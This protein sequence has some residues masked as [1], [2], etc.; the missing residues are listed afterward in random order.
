M[1]KPPNNLLAAFVEFLFVTITL[2]ERARDLTVA[3]DR[4]LQ[5]LMYSPYPLR[6]LMVMFRGEMSVGRK[7]VRRATRTL[8]GNEAM[9][10]A[11]IS[12]KSI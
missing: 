5:S 1:Q 10:V 12:V 8:T 11:V 4:A 7:W 6:T 9:P 2:Q 3:D